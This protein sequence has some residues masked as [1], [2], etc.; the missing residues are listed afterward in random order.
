MSYFIVSDEESY[1]P[2]YSDED[3]DDDKI[4]ESHQNVNDARAGDNEHLNQNALDVG[5]QA[6]CTEDNIL[7]GRDDDDEVSKGHN[8]FYYTYLME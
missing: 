7:L 5:L 6:E 2:V 8:I 4:E 1:S 3:D